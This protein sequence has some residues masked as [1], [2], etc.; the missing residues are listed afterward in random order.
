MALFKG[1]QRKL[2]VTSRCKSGLHK[3]SA[4]MHL[5]EGKTL[6]YTPTA[7]H[8]TKR[9]NHCYFMG[10]VKVMKKDSDIQILFMSQTVLMPVWSHGYVYKN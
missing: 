1:V 8:S 5:T 4:M 6:N 3:S 2:T 7:E 9:S 10:I